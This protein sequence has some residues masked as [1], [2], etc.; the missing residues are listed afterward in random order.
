MSD[1]GRQLEK[2]AEKAP[3]EV[4]TTSMW[5]WFKD[6]PVLAVW[7]F[8][9]VLQFVGILAFYFFSIRDRLEN[10]E[11]RVTRIE[12]QIVTIKESISRIEAS[13]NTLDEKVDRILFGLARSGLDIESTATGEVGLQPAD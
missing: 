4:A 10:V 8:S 1:P 2:P 9:I 3:V 12:Y 7:M 6:N 13:V 5:S 11:D